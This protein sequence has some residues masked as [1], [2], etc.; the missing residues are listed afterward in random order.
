VDL[1]ERG[2]VDAVLMDVQMPVMDGIEATR[3][4][5]ELERARG[6]HTPIIALTAHAMTGDRDRCLA[7][8]MDRYMSKPIQIDAV[9]A[10]L[11]ELSDPGH[12]PSLPPA[13]L[14][15]TALMASLDGDVDLAVQLSSM[16][17][18][19]SE[20]LLKTMWA[21]QRRDDAAGFRMAVHSLKG[22]LANFERGV[23]FESARRVEAAVRRGDFAGIT[24][25]ELATL[26]RET[27]RVAKALRGF[28]QRLGAAPVEDL[29]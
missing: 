1:W 8:G 6:T 25:E 3:T 22:A 16:F 2:G 29:R 23:A 10:A 5:R 9:A 17:F 20:E 7:A 28:V 27:R 24:D 13:A 14:D 4:I 11:D 18:E 15:E 19:E 21:C 26:E 12:S